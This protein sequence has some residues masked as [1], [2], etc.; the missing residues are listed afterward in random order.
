MASFL[1]STCCVAGSRVR[2]SRSREHPAGRGSAQHSTGRNPV[3]GGIT[4]ESSQ[5]RVLVGW[6]LKTSPPC[7]AAVSTVSFRGLP[8]SGMMRNGQLFALTGSAPHISA[9][10]C[11]LSPGLPVRVDPGRGNPNRESSAS[12]GVIVSQGSGMVRVSTF[13]GEMSVLESWVLPLWP[14]L[15]KRGDGNNTGG[16]AQFLRNGLALNAYL[17]GPVAP[18]F[19]E[20]LMGFPIGWT[21]LAHSGTQLSLF[22]PRLSAD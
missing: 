12:I 21:A 18:A 22:A 3:Y 15:T 5:K 13:G 6:S 4:C 19:A 20:W 7:A 10:G 8:A 9:A 1:L 16:A 2:M 17:H 11:L 14:T